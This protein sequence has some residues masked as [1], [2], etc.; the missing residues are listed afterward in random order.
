MRPRAHCAH[1]QAHLV[2]CWLLY[3][4]PV[5]PGLTGTGRAPRRLHRAALDREAWT[6]YVLKEAVVLAY[7]RAG[8]ARMAR[9]AAAQLGLLAAT[10]PKTGVVKLLLARADR[11]AFGGAVSRESAA[12]AL[13]AARAIAAGHRRPRRS[14]PAAERTTRRARGAK[15]AD[16][17]VEASEAAPPGAGA[18]G[19]HHPRP[20]RPGR[21]AADAAER[22]L[23][24]E[25]AAQLWSA[26]RD[27]AAARPR[28]L[29][30][31]PPP[32]AQPSAA[33]AQRVTVR[34]SDVGATGLGALPAGA[35]QPAAPAPAGDAGDRDAAAQLAEALWGAREPGTAA[36]SGTRADAQAGN[37]AARRPPAAPVPPS[38]AGEP[39]DGAAQVTARSGAAALGAAG[40][41]NTRHRLAQE[42]A[43]AT[44]ALLSAEERDLDDDLDDWGAGMGART[45]RMG[46][47]SS[48][49]GRPVA[50]EAGAG[51][52]AP[53][54]PSRA[55]AR[56]IAPEVR[57]L[58]AAAR[59]A[60][61]LRPPAG[62]AGGYGGHVGAPGEAPDP[63]LAAAPVCAADAAS[64]DGGMD[65]A[66]DGSAP[67]TAHCTAAPASTAGAA[68][69][70][71]RDGG[72]AGT[73]ESGPA[74]EVADS[75]A[76]R[77][78]A[79][80]AASTGGCE[81]PAGQRSSS[82]VASRPCVR[83]RAADEAEAG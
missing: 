67:V 79:A 44:G 83:L 20:S 64:V 55:R 69:M 60:G 18:A 24:A 26:R 21:A 47:A 29:A 8:E 28:P 42:Q 62:G 19:A 81:G 32:D 34:H 72:A 73:A 52:P 23:A 9:A 59:R 74:P 10:G 61:R 45:A 36:R 12:E 75:T 46:A 7:W 3:V 14:G 49:L 2:H 38:G 37:G 4:P 35:A 63:A 31:A 57:D 33:A 1:M 41:P 66:A 78:R 22:E 11:W 16:G 30:A 58:G 71:G 77:L 27:P 15:R 25:R 68:S 6:G 40:R 56:T 50:A 82:A 54:A 48:A 65:G 5:P 76:A 53:A 51:G 39:L 80:R 43:E 17:R 70:A 13:E